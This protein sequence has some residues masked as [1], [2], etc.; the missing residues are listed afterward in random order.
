MWDDFRLYFGNKKYFE[1]YEI[2][3]FYCHDIAL[4]AMKYKNFIYDINILLVFNEIK[5]V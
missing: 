3:D 4:I 1:V 5:N 2:L